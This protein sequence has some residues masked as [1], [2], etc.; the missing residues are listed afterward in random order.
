MGKWR[1]GEM[2]NHSLIS[3][4]HPVC[5]S[6]RRIVVSGLYLR[7]ASPVYLPRMEKTCKPLHYSQPG[8]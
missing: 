5:L 1:N 2:K 3:S 6:L 8:E 4:C 7:L